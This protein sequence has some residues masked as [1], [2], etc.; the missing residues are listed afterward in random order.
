MHGEKGLRFL[1]PLCVRNIEE[2][3]DEHHHQ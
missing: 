2:D 1:L 3:A